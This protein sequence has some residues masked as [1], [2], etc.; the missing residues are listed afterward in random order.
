MQPSRFY[1]FARIA[2]AIA[3]AL[4]GPTEALARAGG[5]QGFGGGGGGGFGGDDFGGG[6]WSL[7]PLLFL[8][9][10]SGFGGLFVFLIILWAINRRSRAANM[11]FLAGTPDSGVQPTMLATPMPSRTFDP[12]TVENGLTAIKQRDP[13]FDE[14]AFLD[15]AQTAFFKL[16][17]AW[18]AR[19]QD[20]ARDVMS[21]ALY[22]RHKMQ[23]DQLI[24]A[25][26]TDV[27]ENIVIGSA[28]IVDVRAGMPFDSIVVAMTAS[29]TDYTID[30]RTKQVVSGD[31]YQQTFTEYWTFIRRSD[32][33]SVVGAT[34]LAS[35][36]PNCGAPLHLNNGKCDYCGAYSRTTSA[37]WVVDTI[38]QTR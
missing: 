17:Q 34:A 20:I 16:Q 8:G 32:A 35:T 21:D 13:N 28:R 24:A 4:I 38:E 27:L 25:H 22:E 23:T 18:N 29:M 31:R 14:R 11:G 10:G 33:K 37:D 6:L 19:D 3:L 36:C 30:D 2:A 12:S 26:Q 5:G 1:L 9:H 7:W 15:R